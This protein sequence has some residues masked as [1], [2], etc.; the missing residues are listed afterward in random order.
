MAAAFT[1]EPLEAY[2][3][4]GRPSPPARRPG[5][6]PGVG[7]LGG[8][9]DRAQAG[10]R[11]PPRPGRGRSLDRLR[12]LGELSRQHPRRP[13]PV[14][15]QAAPPP[16]RGLAGPVPTRLAPPIRTAPTTRGRRARYGR[17]ARRRARPRVRGRR[18]RHRRGVRRRADRRGDPRRRRPARRLLAGDR[19]G[20][21]PPWRP[22]HRRRGHD[23]VRPD[24]PLVRARPLGRPAGHPG[25]G[26]G[27]HL[28]LLAVRVR[29]GVAAR[30][31]AR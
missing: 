29:R 4:R 7:R 2:A 28:G 18:P 6:L 11:V 30:S 21:P 14:G 3:A 12:S 13:R 1:T 10:P 8:D 17:G 27:R 24:R 19:R 31:T 22:A 20:L 16:V 26:Q 25:G 9:R 23:R 5:H 15:A